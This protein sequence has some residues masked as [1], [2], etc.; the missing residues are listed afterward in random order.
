MRLKLRLMMG[1]VGFILDIDGSEVI[2][3][4]YPTEIS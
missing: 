2:A 3:E 4:S 1:I